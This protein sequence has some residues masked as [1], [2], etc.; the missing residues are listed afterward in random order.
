M[1]IIDID[2]TKV[3][4]GNYLGE[5]ILFNKTYMVE[6]S[7]SNNKIEVINIKQ[8]A[9]SRWAKKAEA[10]I[11]TIMEKQ[12]ADVDVITGATVTSKVLLKAVENALRKGLR[13]KD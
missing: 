13:E 4:S 10:V 8:N 12:R 1:P 11:S 7:V 3:Q 5:Y 9:D 6:V 2:L